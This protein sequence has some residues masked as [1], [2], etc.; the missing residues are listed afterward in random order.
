ME[1]RF[2]ILGDSLKTANLSELLLIQRNSMRH[3]LLEGIRIGVSSWQFL[4][5]I[6]Y[7]QLKVTFP[8]LFFLSA[9]CNTS[10]PA[11]SKNGKGG[12]KIH[13][14]KYVSTEHGCAK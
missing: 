7:F 2:P 13:V 9:D 3:Y 6:S 8:I 1:L 4:E 10:W 14:F 11:Y 5:L 12:G